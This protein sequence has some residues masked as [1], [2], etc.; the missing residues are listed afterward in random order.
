M[1][2]A[3]P[4]EAVSPPQTLQ[5]PGVC[6]AAPRPQ[7]VEASRV[8]RSSRATEA[9]F[10]PGPVPRTY[11]SRGFSTALKRAHKAISGSTG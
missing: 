4:Q 5:R 1:D 6:P 9:A 10:H 2:P 3:S 11:L 7:G 8:K